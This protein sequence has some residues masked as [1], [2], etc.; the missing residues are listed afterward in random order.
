MAKKPTPVDIGYTSAQEWWNYIACPAHSRFRDASTKENMFECAKALEDVRGWRW[1]DTH[2]GID[3][4]G[5][6]R[7][8]EAFNQRLF[9]ACPEL[10]LIKD[11]AEIAKHGGQLS[12]N[13][14]KVDSIVGSG[15]GGAEYLSDELGMRERKPECMLR[16]RLKDG[17]EVPIPQMLVRAMQY[18]RSE[19][20]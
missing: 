1:R 6:P 14:V 7:K 16:A 17:S 19:L 3:T 18:W 5:A 8:Y 20:M 9:T 11:I 15:I 2:P 4:R 13:S 10:E 12:R